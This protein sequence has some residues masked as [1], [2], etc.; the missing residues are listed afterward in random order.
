MIALIG[1]PDPLTYSVASALRAQGR[2]VVICRLVD[3]DPEGDLPGDQIAFRIEHLGTLLE[4]LVAMGVTE[5]CLVGAVSRPRV[6][7]SRIDAATL[8]LMP[9]I[10]AA[11]REGDDGALRALIALL[12]EMGLAVRAAHELAPSL[13]PPA[14]VLSVARPARSHEADVLRAEAVHRIIAPADIGQ[15]LV[16]RDGQVLAVEAAPGT[17]WMLRSLR[18]QAEGAVFY[19]APKRCQDRRADLPVIGPATIDRAREAGIAA[20]VIEAGGVMMLNRE[21]AVAHADAAG[22]V[23]WVREPGP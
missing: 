19:K 3:H 5:A 4:R 18:G 11:M 16:V 10:A 1:N 23:L 15:G 20:V 7:P 17:D 2:P 14:G 22:I 9:R 13:L 12:E 8:P 21:I 6:D